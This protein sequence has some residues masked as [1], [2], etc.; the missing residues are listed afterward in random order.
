[1]RHE[2]SMYGERRTNDN[3][4][5]LGSQESLVQIDERTTTRRRKDGEGSCQAH[6]TYPKDGGLQRRGRKPPTSQELGSAPTTRGEIGRVPSSVEFFIMRYA[7][8]TDHW[9]SVGQE[10]RPIA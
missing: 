6:E 9:R 8:H 2:R 1:V 7:R 3:H 5:G 4:S 10:P